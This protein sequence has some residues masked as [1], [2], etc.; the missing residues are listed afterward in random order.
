[1]SLAEQDLHLKLYHNDDD[2]DDGDHGDKANSGSEPVSTCVH[3]QDTPSDAADGQNEN[4]P[5]HPFNHGYVARRS[6]GSAGEQ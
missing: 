5:H 3:S 2:H 6:V 1:M 4:A